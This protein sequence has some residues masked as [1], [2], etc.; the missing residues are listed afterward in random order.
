MRSFVILSVGAILANAQSSSVAVTTAPG[1]P[2]TTTQAPNNN[3]VVTSASGRVVTT[4]APGPPY[5]P[6]SCSNPTGTGMKCLSTTTF[7]ICDHGVAVTQGDSPIVTCGVNT[8]CCAGKTYC[9]WDSTC[10]GT[11]NP[12]TGAGT[13]G[14]V[15]NNG[16]G[17]SPQTTAAAGGNANNGGGYN[18]SQNTG[19]CANKAND[20]IACISDTQFKVCTGGV[21]AYDTQT[22]QPGLRC[23]ESL[24]GCDWATGPIN[25]G[26]AN[27]GNNGGY[28]PGT[29]VAN[30]GTC[31]NKQSGQIACVSNSS[32]KVCGDPALQYCPSGLTC[33]EGTNSCNW[34]GYN[35]QPNGGGHA[36]YV[37]GTGAANTGTCTGK[38][39]DQIAC[40]TNNTF[41]VCSGGAPAAGAAQTCQTGL[42]CYESTNSCGWSNGAAV[43]VPGPIAHNTGTCTNKPDKFIACVSDTTFKI[44]SGGAPAYGTQSCQAG[45]TCYE[46]TNS[47]GWTGGYAPGTGA[48]NTGTCTN[49]VNNAIAC[50][51][52]TQFQICTNGAPAYGVQSCQPGLHCYEA[53]NSCG[54]TNGLWVPGATGST[55]IPFTS[56]PTKDFCDTQTHD[57]D[58]MGKFCVGVRSNMWC[59]DGELSRINFCPSDQIC[60]ENSGEC[61]TPSKSCYVPKGIPTRKEGCVGKLNSCADLADGARVCTGESTFSYCLDQTVFAPLKQSCPAGTKC[62]PELGGRCEEDGLYPTQPVGHCDDQPDGATVCNGY[63]SYKVC[64]NGGCLGTFDCIGDDYVCCP[65]TGSCAPKGQCDSTTFWPVVDENC[66][67]SLNK[68]V[69]TTDRDEVHVCLNG[70]LVAKFPAAAG[71]NFGCDDDTLFPDSTLYN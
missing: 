5:Y 6:T 42:S 14:Y 21:A 47:C 66:L 64:H 20:K 59:K 53:T 63:K 22:C 50:I 13:G 58:H 24:N 71:Y 28:V 1:A 2:A 67:G 46:A 18:P 34:P 19:S 35:P 40:V 69:C 10:G 56:G 3:N 31:T 37:P 65:T 57:Y 7:N 33:S 30:T 8:F 61:G 39:N 36:I 16:G 12:S 54:W 23:I 49:K 25:G 32:Y 17:G 38:R 52:D 48:A 45:L 41:K 62:I 68:R 9:D 60:C 44:C 55:V 43:Y 4:A 29:G 26:N 15:P 11:Y 51:S 27:G 70:H